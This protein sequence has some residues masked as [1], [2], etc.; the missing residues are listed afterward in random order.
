MFLQCRVGR[1]WPLNSQRS[2]SISTD[3]EGSKR[4][5]FADSQRGHQWG[6]C[7]PPDRPWGMG[8][9]HKEQPC[10]WAAGTLRVTSAKVWILE[11][12]FFPLSLFKRYLEKKTGKLIKDVSCYCLSALLFH[13][14]LHCIFCSDSGKV[15]PAFLLLM[16]TQSVLSSYQGLKPGVVLNLL[17]AITFYFVSVTLSRSPPWQCLP[18]R[19]SV[20][21]WRTAGVVS[22][23]CGRKRPIL[24]SS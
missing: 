4:R 15:C 18:L 16:T 1:L 13:L 14:L 24:C 19:L 17:H 6:S 21:C 23:Q 12:C 2:E 11:S 10:L 8:H 20:S 9:C 7:P 22:L 3:G 5:W